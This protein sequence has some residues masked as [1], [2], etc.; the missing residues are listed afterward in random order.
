MTPLLFGAIGLAGGLGSAARFLLDGVSASLLTGRYPLGMFVA[1]VSGSLLLGLVTG[2]AV[3]R[4]LHP[5][6]ELIL[7]VGLLGGY[8]T[9]SAASLEPVLP[10]RQRRMLAALLHSIGML[11]TSIG[12]AAI[13]YSVG[14]AL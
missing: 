6:L 13:G 14:A 10:V 1:N 3:A 7:G 12:A 8:T 4:L 9:F 5:D 2:L 11:I